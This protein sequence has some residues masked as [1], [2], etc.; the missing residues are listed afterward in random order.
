MRVLRLAFLILGPAIF[1]ALPTSFFEG[2][3]SLCLVKNL[4]GF[5][6]PGCG[7]TRACSA[8]IHGD[9]VAAIQF[10]GLIVVIA[11]LLC[12]VLVRE[13]FAALSGLLGSSQGR[14]Y[15]GVHQQD[16]NFL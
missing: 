12:Y 15:R 13:L 11:P 9:V 5:E 4:S 1:I 14:E 8:L 6:C 3:H 7:L 2:G 16:S 10:N